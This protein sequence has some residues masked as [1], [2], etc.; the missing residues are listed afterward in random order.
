[1]LVREFPGRVPLLL[2]VPR[3]P[4]VVPEVARA[5]VERGARL[6]ERPTGLPRDDRVASGVPDAVRPLAG[7]DYPV[8]RLERIDGP[9]C[10]ALALERG[11][12]RKEAVPV[13]LPED[14]RVLLM[15]ADGV[16]DRH[17]LAERVDVRGVEVT[18]L[19][20]TVAPQLEAV[21]K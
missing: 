13:V 1:M 17:Q 4:E 18:N 2:G 19:A 21:G 10:L 11:A 7:L 8:P 16:Q 3:H 20:E 9:A 12:L 14:A 15:H 5:V 6:R